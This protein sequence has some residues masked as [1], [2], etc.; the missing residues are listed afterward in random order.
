MHRVLFVVHRK[1][2]LSRSEFLSHYENVHYPIARTFPNLRRYETFPLPPGESDETDPDA[3]AV[4]T[5]DSVGDFE[6]ALASPE[7]AAA[8]ADNEN[9]VDHFDTFVVD[10]VEV[11]S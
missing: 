6:K 4:M 11:V 5:F 10:N 7:F 1:R 2:D 8:V 9:F 3:F